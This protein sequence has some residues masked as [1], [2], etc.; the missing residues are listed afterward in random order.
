MEQL[1]LLLS[2]FSRVRLLATP[3][4]AAHQAPPSIQQQHSAV[5]RCV[6]LC[7]CI[8]IYIC[9]T[10]LSIHLSKYILGCFDILAIVNNATMN[11]EEGV[12]LFKL[13]FSP[14]IC[15][16]VGLLGDMVVLFLVF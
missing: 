15:P 2:R 10:S 1:L 11:I 3:W 9:A 4:T 6:Y 13:E 5:C 8:Y 14:D 7:V 16:G 12:Y